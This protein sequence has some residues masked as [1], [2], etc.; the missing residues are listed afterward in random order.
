MLGLVAGID[1]R[2]TLLDVRGTERAACSCACSPR[3]RTA[4]TAAYSGDV[5]RADA[6]VHFPLGTT[7]LS[8]RWN[9]AWGEPDA[10]PF[11]LGGSISDPPTLLPILNQREFALRGYTSGEP[12]LTGNRARITTA[13]WR[14]PLKRRRPAR[15]GA[16][17]RTQPARAEPVLRRRR[18]VGARRRSRLSPRRR[19]RADGRGALRLPVRRRPAHRRWPRASTKAARPPAT[20]GSAARSE[21]APAEKIASRRSRS[22]ITTPLGGAGGLARA[23]ARLPAARSSAADRCCRS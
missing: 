9:E 18:G 17:G 3:L 7:V 1:T 13:E 4:C 10:E 19:R 5:Y 14:I 12:T 21:S 11:Q 6:R 15:H 2:R 16:A 8:L 23:S 20:S 22:L